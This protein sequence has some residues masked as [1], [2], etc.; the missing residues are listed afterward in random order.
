[1]EENK[2]LVTLMRESDRLM[3]SIV[4]NA[5]EITPEIET[6]IDVNAASISLKI[7]KYNFILERIDKEIE[8]FDC[9]ERQMKT[10]K[11]SFE[12]TKQQ[13]RNRIK[14]IMLSKGIKELIGKEYKF[15]LSE[16][17]PK[18]IVDESILPSEYKMQVV[19]YESDKDLI[20]DAIKSGKQ[21]IGA[22]FEKVY[23]LRTYFNKGE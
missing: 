10:I 13:I 18:L 21:I 16:S 20:K 11:K 23:L 4:E 2:S 1:M 12:S 7:D 3:Q 9:K 5:G 8:F 17:Q 6:E 15:V 22:I 14:D 19:S